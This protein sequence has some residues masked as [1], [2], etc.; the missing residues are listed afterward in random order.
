MASLAQKAGQKTPHERTAAI[1]RD[2]ES[3][4]TSSA[5]SGVSSVAGEDKK[6]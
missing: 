5:V 6:T 2:I 3:V 4:E 1:K